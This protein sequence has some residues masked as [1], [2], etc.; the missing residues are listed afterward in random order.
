MPLEHISKYDTPSENGA[1]ALAE[2]VAER[3]GCLVMVE[4]SK[5]SCFGVATGVARVIAGYNTAKE[6]NRGC[7]QIYKDESIRGAKVVRGRIKYNREKREVLAADEQEQAYIRDVER[8]IHESEDYA[9]RD[10]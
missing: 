3:C 6:L 4:H 10:V 9:Q 2:I 5:K 7:Y 8:G 1:E